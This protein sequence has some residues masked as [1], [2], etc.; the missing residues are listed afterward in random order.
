[1]LNVTVCTTKCGRYPRFVSTRNPM[2][3]QSPSSRRHR[4][5]KP[6]HALYGIQRREP[7]LTGTGGR[8]L[9]AIRRRGAYYDQSFADAAYQSP[10]R[11]LLVAQAFRDAL[12]DRL[13]APGRFV[14]RAK[15]TDAAGQP[16]VRLRLK[17]GGMHWE[18]AFQ[19]NGSKRTRSFAIDKYGDDMAYLL[20]VQ[21]RI[22]WEHQHGVERKAANLP[23]KE[24]VAQ[25][26]QVIRER[27][28][29]GSRAKGKRHKT[30]NDDPMYGI[31]R[32][33][34]NAAGKGG[35]WSV[36]IKRRRARHSKTFRDT[37]YGGKNLALEVARRY[38]DEIL[39]SV[40]PL[41]VQERHRIIPNDNSSGV[42][43]VSLRKQHGRPDSW[44]AFITVQGR[45][46]SRQ[47]S[48]RKL[49]SERAFALAVQARE[50]MLAE[51]AEG[52]YVL[53]PAAKR[54]I[55]GTDSTRLSAPR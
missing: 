35:R 32:H 40:E 22:V 3:N 28:G 14:V 52:Y 20:A 9:V 8:W 34:Q 36:L 33:E 4:P 5:L 30:Y 25:L 42:P 38:R 10:E 21:T 16:G 6:G 46:R 18:A 37:A 49:G 27:F 15:V 12:L 39:A 53:S 7:T 41:S 29:A 50:A 2:S 44:R 31:Y 13:P 23:T 43:G 17:Q 51:L 26:A 45:T 11:A 48:I 47:F 24:E 55:D 19:V 54:S 1:M